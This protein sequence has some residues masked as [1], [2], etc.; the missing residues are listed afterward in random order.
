MCVVDIFK[1]TLMNKKALERFMK[2]CCKKTQIKQLRIE[3]VKNKKGYKLYIKRK[4]CDN[5]FNGWTDKEDMV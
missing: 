2:N 1:E 5:S 3:K 4:V